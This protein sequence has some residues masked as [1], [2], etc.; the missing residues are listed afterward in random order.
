MK[1]TRAAIAKLRIPDGKSEFLVFD[2]DLAGFGLRLRA[3][4]SASWIIQ[5]RLGARQRRMTIGRLKGTAPDQARTRAAELL[6]KVRLGEDPQGTKLEARHAIP[7]KPLLLGQLTDLYLDAAERRQKASTFT[8]TRRHLSR[9]WSTLHAMPVASIELEHVA[10]EIKRIATVTGP[11]NANRA[12]ANLSAMFSWAMGEGLAP[13]NPVI[14]TNKAAEEKPRERV[15]TTDEIIVVWQATSSA[16]DFDRL[17]RLLLLTGQRREEL[18]SMRWSELD[19]EKCHWLLPSERTKNGRPHMV[20]LSDPTL[21]ILTNVRRIEGRDLVFGR[22]RGGFSGWSQCKARL[23][24]RTGVTGWR[25]HDLRRTVVTSMAELGIQPHVIEAVVNHQSGHKSGIAG[26][27]NKATY[28]AE[29]VQAMALWANC[30]VSVAAGRPEA[31][32]V[33][34]V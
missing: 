13:R 9:N 17:V 14:G 4:G 34:R 11:I 29:K 7:V 33:E 30:V 24:K 25:L 5:Y 28:G 18:A 20:P 15:L 27:Y 8:E 23:D 12:R 31:V 21:A 16:S 26:V 10:A 1:L 3:G 6:A 32:S 19:L 22:G 2:D